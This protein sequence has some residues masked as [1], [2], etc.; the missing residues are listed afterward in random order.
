MP[1]ATVQVRHT[2]TTSTS[3]ASVLVINTGYLTSKLGLLKLLILILSLVSFILILLEIERYSN[4]HDSDRYLM[5][6]SFGDWLTVA[7]MLIAALLSLGT[8]SILPK[9]SFD[10]MFHFFMGILIFVGGLL[11]SLNAFGR[12]ERN[13]K[14]QTSC[15]LA[16]VCGVVQIVHGIFSYRLCVTN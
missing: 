15:V 8:A 13:A 11:V 7:I 2:T 4:Y 9:T 16:M 6:I 1:T 5:L 14:V 10:F 12:T 3:R